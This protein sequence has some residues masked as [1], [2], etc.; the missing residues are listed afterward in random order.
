MTASLNSRV[1]QFEADVTLTHQL[2]HAAE[3]S[4]QTD[5]GPLR[6]FAQLQADI[7]AELNAE[8]VMTSAVQ[9][10]LDAEQAAASAAADAIT[11]EAARDAAL[12]SVG[13]YPDIA[14]GR[15][16]TTA[17]QYF[18]VPSPAIAEH[19]ILYRR[20]AAG[21]DEI[22]RYPSAAALAA[23]QATASSVQLAMVSMAASMVST[24][25]EV[26]EMRND[27]DAAIGAGL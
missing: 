12:L 15:A 2:V 6:T 7:E 24:Q 3:G 13:V 14:A 23:A 26:V 11:A 1:A 18:S 21:A 5:S 10:K 4:V 8:V 9:S 25:A 20:S 27:L 22:K 17:G 19:L 16:A